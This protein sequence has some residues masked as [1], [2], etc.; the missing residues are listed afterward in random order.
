MHYIIAEIDRQYVSY[1]DTK[2]CDPK[3]KKLP[4]K[5]MINDLLSI[6]LDICVY[7]SALIVAEKINPTQNY[8]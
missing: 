2:I 4:S 1:Y 6:F 7:I 3:N 8:I 5:G